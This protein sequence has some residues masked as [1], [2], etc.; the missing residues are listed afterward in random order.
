MMNPW[1]L[2]DLVVRMQKGD[3]CDECLIVKRII[4]LFILFIKRTPRWLLF[5]VVQTLSRINNSARQR[6]FST[7]EIPKDWMPVCWPFVWFVSVFAFWFSFT[8]A[9]KPGW[10][11]NTVAAAERQTSIKLIHHIPTEVRMC[12]DIL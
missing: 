9:R 2:F 7:P 5:G 3:F 4:F 8:L 10:S 12:D 11:Y 1:N 6:T